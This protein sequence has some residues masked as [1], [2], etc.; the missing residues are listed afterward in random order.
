MD[1][2]EERGPQDQEVKDLAEIIRGLRKTQQEICE[3]RCG[4]HVEH[5]AS[6]CGW[7]K[8]LTYEIDALDALLVPRLA[9]QAVLAHLD[10]FA[11]ELRRHSF[12]CPYRVGGSPSCTCEAGAAPM[13]GGDRG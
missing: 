4:P 13:E 2:Q 8:S 7:C 3:V 11:K 10:A 5:R 6:H 12:R 1:K 9:S